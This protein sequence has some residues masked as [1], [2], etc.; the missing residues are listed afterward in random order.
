M[1][2]HHNNRTSCGC[3]CMYIF[4]YVVNFIISYSFFEE[5]IFYISE[6]RNHFI[7]LAEKTLGNK[8]LSHVP[9][10]HINLNTMH[11]TCGGLITS[12]YLCNHYCC[13]VHS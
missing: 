8:H 9:S 1:I 10:R 2:L 13:E 4:I 12:S 6:H 7:N 5:Y 11:N 3:H